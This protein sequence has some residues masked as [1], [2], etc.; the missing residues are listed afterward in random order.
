MNASLDQQR[1]ALEAIDRLLNRGGDA[2]DILR[3]V[4]AV[5][6]RLY[7]DVALFFVD[8]D[9]LTHGPKLG[10]AG[11]DPRRVFPVSFQGTKV[12]ELQVAVGAEDDA[13]LERVATLVSAHCLVGWDTRGVPWSEVE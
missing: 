7:P 2:D 3:E 12:A 9:R 4:V 13:F 1:G 8:G 5:L 10:E 11:L 6:G